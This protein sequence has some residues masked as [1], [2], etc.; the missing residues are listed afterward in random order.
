MEYLKFK[1]IITKNIRTGLNRY[2]E[3]IETMI[4]SPERFTGIFRLTNI[5]NKVIQNVTQSNEIKLGDAFEDLVTEYLSYLG[6]E[7]K[8]KTLG[9]DTNGDE[10]RADQIFLKNEVIYLVEQKIRDDHDSTKK[11]GQF[12]NFGKKIKL[13]KSKFPNKYLNASMWFIDDGFKKNKN[14]YLNEITSTAFPN[15]KLNLFY[16]GEFFHMLIN[17]DETWNEITNHLKRM[18]IE[19][20]NEMILIPDFDTSEL[21]YES[22]KALSKNYFKKLVSGDLKYK[23]LI[24]EFFPTQKNIIRLINELEGKL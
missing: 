10:L 11:R 20:D 7:N 22:L 9:R 2:T 21:G 12:T 23:V 18:K 16:G 14:Y 5:K 13:L 19:N 3:L 8:P 15:T 1:S 24:E 17:G 4:D 6:Y